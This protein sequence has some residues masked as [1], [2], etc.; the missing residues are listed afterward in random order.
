[1]IGRAGIHIQ[2][3]RDE[4]GARII[5]QGADDADRESVTI[6]GTKEVVVAAKT[7]V[8]AYVKEVD[9]IVEDAMII[10]P[11]HLKH[12]V[13]RMKGVAA[14]RVNLN[15][16]K[17]FIEAKDKVVAKE[18]LKP[19][20]VV[21]DIEGVQDDDCN[22][23]G[24]SCDDY[25]NLDTNNDP[26]T[27]RNE[28]DILKGKLLPLQVILFRTDSRGA[29]STKGDFFPSEPKEKKKCEETFGSQRKLV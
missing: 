1:M 7:I 22:E 17:A 29:W 15:D 5:F 20:E 24:D 23:N 10:E 16:A 27:D 28:A 13:A 4:T 11:K 12:F 18:T 2:K 25:E 26:I 21:D 14:D 6:I 8:E 9:N 3:I 19:G